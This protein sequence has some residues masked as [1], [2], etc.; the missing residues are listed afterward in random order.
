METLGRALGEKTPRGTA[1][2][3]WREV[4]SPPPP[5]TRE[6]E[7]ARSASPAEAP[8]ERH[9]ARLRLETPLGKVLGGMGA[10]LFRKLPEFLPMDEDVE[11]ETRGTAAKRRDRGAGRPWARTPKR[12]GTISS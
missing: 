8:R 6:D 11:E 9:P 7:A 10:N 5:P 2:R 3:A 1:A 4:S 12:R